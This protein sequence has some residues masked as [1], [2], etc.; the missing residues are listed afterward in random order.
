MTQL[1][2]IRVRIPNIPNLERAIEI[3]YENHLL[4]KQ[5]IKELFGCS[6]G[7]AYKLKLLVKQKN[8][9]MPVWDNQTVDT[10]KAFSTWGLNVEDLELRVKRL[11]KLRE[12]TGK[13]SS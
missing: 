10:K 12:V 7:T 9:E 4:D 8:P 3:Y 6:D 11:Y 2:D 5:L 1:T 13:C